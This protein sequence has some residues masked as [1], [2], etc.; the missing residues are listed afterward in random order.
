MASLQYA[1]SEEL[2]RVLSVEDAYESFWNDKIHDKSAFQCPGNNCDAKVT[3]ACMDIKE[4]ELKQTP[5]FRVYGMHSPDCEYVKYLEDEKRSSSGTGSVLLTQQNCVEL[6]LKRE[7][8]FQLKPILSPTDSYLNSRKKVIG[9]YGK[10]SSRPKYYTIRPIVE[11]FFEYHDD[12]L[13]DSN[14]VRIDGTQV[15][16]KKLFKG[17]YNQNVIDWSDCKLIFWGLCYINNSKNNTYQIN[18]TEKFD[19][20]GTLYR[21]S[22]FIKKEELEKYTMAKRL[23]MYINEETIINSIQYFA[24]I[25]G[26]PSVVIKNTGKV[27]IN[28]DLSSLD[29]IDFRSQDYFSKLQRKFG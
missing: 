14:F 29:F 24:F 26:S 12:G 19:Y 2:K 13:L 25:Y 7:N 17:I 18:F 22:F 27:Y 21:P 6:I 5:H 20:K 4:T 3:C 11:K 10:Y 16:Y 28:F 23:K 15:S 8:D 1:Y 9:G